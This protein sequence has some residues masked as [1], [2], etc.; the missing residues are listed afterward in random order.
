LL[1]DGLLRIRWR[2]PSG[3]GDGRFR[4]GGSQDAILVPWLTL[5]RSTVSV[6]KVI[7]TFIGIVTYSPETM[8]ESVFILRN[9]VRSGRAGVGKRAVLTESNSAQR[10]GMSGRGGLRQR[11]ELHGR[12]VGNCDHEEHDD[13]HWDGRK[14]GLGSR[15]IGTRKSGRGHSLRLARLKPT[16]SAIQDA[17]GSHHDDYRQLGVHAQRRLSPNQVRSSGGCHQH[18][19]PDKD[20]LES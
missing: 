16:L 17:V 18:S 7:P 12:L 1:T 5:P 3:N 15:Q 2:R 13:D 19:I 10:L 6:A 4:P 14:L 11:R 9:D 20:R 8:R